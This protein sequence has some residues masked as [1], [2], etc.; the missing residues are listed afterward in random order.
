MRLGWGTKVLDYILRGFNH[1]DCNIIIIKEFS[2]CQ[3]ITN[4][5]VND[6]VT[7]VLTNV[8]LK[9]ESPIY[10]YYYQYA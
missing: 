7:G 8:K 5:V 10:S 2:I 6:S 9:R 3:L 1:R 4:K